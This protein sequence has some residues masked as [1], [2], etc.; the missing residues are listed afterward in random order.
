M[1]DL[2]KNLQMRI[3]ARGPSGEHLSLLAGGE[4]LEELRNIIVFLC[5]AC[6]ASQ[7]HLH[8]PFHVMSGL[9][10]QAMTHLVKNLP[11]ASCLSLFEL[12]LNCRSQGEAACYLTENPPPT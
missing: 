7:N 5:Q 11:H 2:T 6:P 9:S 4:A 3:A 8:C 10:Y 12:E 1:N